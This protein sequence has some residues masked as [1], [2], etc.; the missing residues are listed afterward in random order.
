M[1]GVKT[2]KTGIRLLD[3]AKVTPQAPKNF[4][5]VIQAK[6]KDNYEEHKKNIAPMFPVIDDIAENGVEVGGTKY[7][8]KQSSGGDQV[9]LAKAAGHL[10]HS[11]ANGCFLC[12]AHKNQYGKV[13]V[14]ATGK[15]VPLQFRLR[16]LEELC[17]GAQRPLST[18]PFSKCPYCPQTFPDQATVDSLESP[19]NKNQDIKYATTH[20]GMRF[21]TPPLF[22][23]PL[24][25][26]YICCLHGLLQLAAVTF[27]RIIEQT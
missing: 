1:H 3:K 10:G 6:E 23:F 14:D 27:Q 17:A 2:A 25:M 24:N 21:G 8:V 9:F 4:R 15:R 5:I 19:A 20:L 12:N 11:H 7:T 13:V 16:T 22:K 26:W 18:G